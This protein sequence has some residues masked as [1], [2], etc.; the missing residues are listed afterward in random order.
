MSY[1]F[2]ANYDVTNQP[3]YDEYVQAVGP[4]LMQYGAKIVVA[5]HHPI[6]AEGQSRRTLIVLEFE[7]EAAALRWYNSPEYQAI[8]NK[9]INASEGWVR[10][11]PGFEMSA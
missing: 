9:R 3:M 4:T 2:V 10:W 11:A 7:S 5:D 1:Y 8:I 6:P